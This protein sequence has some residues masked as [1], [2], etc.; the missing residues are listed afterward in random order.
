MDRPY[1]Y[2]FTVFIVGIFYFLD[3]IRGETGQKE[4]RE[5]IG[6]VW[7]KF[8][9]AKYSDI[10]RLAA[11]ANNRILFYLFA[12]KKNNIVSSTKTMTFSV[13]VFLLFLFLYSIGQAEVTSHSEFH[14]LSSS[15]KANVAL[16]QFLLMLLTIPIHVGFHTSV[17]H[18]TNSTYLMSKDL[19]V[20]GYSFFIENMLVSLV[21]TA[22]IGASILAFVA[23]SNMSPTKV[24]L[25]GYLNIL[26]FIFIKPIELMTIFF[27]SKFEPA[28]LVLVGAFIIPMLPNFLYALLIMILGVLKL[29]FP[30][31][32]KVILKILYAFFDS[33]HGVFTI[34]GVFIAFIYQMIVEFN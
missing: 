20:R 10:W 13:G 17:T 22:T 15:E 19:A 5:N 3:W 25:G 30:A 31:F 29:I 8:G 12:N 23:I 9:E 21:I 27:N 24:H 4:M 28:E 14:T 11:E 1:D 26:Y 2:V 18:V 7:Q 6:K 33:R 32:K 34:L 16:K